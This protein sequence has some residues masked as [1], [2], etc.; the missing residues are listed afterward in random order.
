[1][2]KYVTTLTEAQTERLSSIY[3]DTTNKDICTE[4]KISL[5]TLHKYAK[6]LGL[7]K[8]QEFM[9][10]AKSGKM[11]SAP[12]SK[13][14]FRFRDR[15]VKR[16]KKVLGE[17]GA[18]D[19]FFQ[20]PNKDNGILN[21]CLKN[22]IF[23]SMGNTVQVPVIDYDGTNGNVEELSDDGADFNKKNNT[24]TPKIVYSIDKIEDKTIFSAVTY[25]IKLMRK[26][27][28]SAAKACSVSAK[29]FDVDVSK[30][31]HYVGQRAQRI[32]QYRYDKDVV[33]YDFFRNI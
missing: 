5:S 11:D 4:L 29:R 1:M 13:N 21:D 14:Y 23:A 3:A 20:Q 15:R 6:K 22:S 26:A 12:E 19:I 10:K 28:T 17:Y 2:Q 32:K 24:N 31:A 33:F 27:G 9:D 30:I 8:S 18:M 7:S 16:A 25:A